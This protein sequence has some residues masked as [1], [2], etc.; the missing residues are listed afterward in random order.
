M[1][2]K[3]MLSFLQTAHDKINV[4]MIAIEDIKDCLYNIKE[5]MNDLRTKE[6]LPIQT[7]GKVITLYPNF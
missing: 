4:P 2:N 3:E 7:T 5:V 6:G 1:D